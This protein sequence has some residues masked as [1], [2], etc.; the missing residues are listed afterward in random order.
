VESEEVFWGLQQ[1]RCLKRKL[2]FSCF[3]EGTRRPSCTR[4]VLTVAGMRMFSASSPMIPGGERQLPLSG[5]SSV[6]SPAMPVRSDGLRLF[7]LRLPGSFSCS[8]DTAVVAEYM[9]AVED[10]A[11]RVANLDRSL[12]PIVRPVAPAF[13]DLQKSLPPKPFSS[14]PCQRAV[15]C[16]SLLCAVPGQLYSSPRLTKRPFLLHQDFQKLMFMSS[17]YPDS[18]SFCAE[19]VVAAL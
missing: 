17:Q 5:S 3:L 10:A 4:N 12:E 16:T 15:R 8:K 14:R 11:E 1:T 6:N 2:N 19:A 18:V 7:F 9:R 13:A